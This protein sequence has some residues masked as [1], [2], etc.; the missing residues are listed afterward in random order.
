METMKD[1]CACLLIFLSMLCFVVI[2]LWLLSL[3]GV[4]PDD[5]CP[6]HCSKE[7]PASCRSRP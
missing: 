4:R 3:M 1:V 7:T 5:P 2:G 6:C